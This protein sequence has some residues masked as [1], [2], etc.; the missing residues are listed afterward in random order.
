M[1]YHFPPIKTKCC[2]RRSGNF[3]SIVNIRLSYNDNDRQLEEG[4]VVKQTC[5]SWYKIIKTGSRLQSYNEA[6]KLS[7][8]IKIDYLFIMISFYPQHL[9]ITGWSI[10]SFFFF[11]FTGNYDHAKWYHHLGRRYIPLYITFFP[12]QQACAVISFFFH[13]Q[14]TSLLWNTNPVSQ[15]TA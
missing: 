6:N 9:K 1:L 10:T 14:W 12:R 13:L 7:R 11:F 2:L 5:T 8:F 3:I 15:V 4:G